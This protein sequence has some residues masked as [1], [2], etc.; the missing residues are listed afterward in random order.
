MDSQRW[1]QIEDILQSAMDRAPAQRDS[2]LRD[3]CG[4]DE[5]LEREV[6]SLLAVERPAD[7][8]LENP[9]IEVAARQ[10]T[11]DAS[12]DQGPDRNHD[13]L[14]G[15][16]LSHYRI[17]GKLGAGGMGQVYRAEDLRLH[18]SVAL[19]F[20]SDDFASDPEALS[21]FRR[22]AQ[23]ASALNHP[24]I[25]TIYDI[26]EV[27]G[28]SFIVMEHLEGA[29]LKQRIAE[30][31]LDAESLLTLGI[32]IADALDA[33]HTAGI[34]H[35]DIKPDNI[36]VTPRGHAKV[37]DFGLARQSRAP[38][39][40]S[41]TVT[42]DD[43]GPGAVVGTVA[44]MSPEQ[45]L[46]KP[47]DTRTDLFSF[48]VMLYE[49]ATGIR[50]FPGNTS[51]AVFAAILHQAPE[52]PVR[53]N[54][55]VPVELERVINKCLEKDRDLRYQHAAE[56][57]ADLRRLKRDADTGRPAVTST[58]AHRPRAGKWRLAIAAAFA[59]LLA[60]AGAAFYYL[61]GFV[62][63]PARLTGKDT[64]VLADFVNT[65]GDPVFD[66][67]MRQ[68]LAVQLEQSPLILL[69][70]QARIQH[71]L[72]LM[73][74]PPDTR[75][76]PEI[77][78]E[79]CQRA[80][81]AAELDGSIT[82][83][84]SKYVLGLTARNC[85]TG[86]ILYQ[87]QAQAEKKEDVLEALSQIARKFRAVVGESPLTLTKYSTPL[88]EATTSSLE[89]LEA[90]SLGLK[91]I[92]TKGPTDALPFF[93]HATELDPKFAT[94]YARLGRCYC[95]VEEVARCAEATRK[96]WELRDRASQ[97]EKYFID[98]SYYR[99]VAHDMAKAQQTCELW[100]QAYPRDMQPHAFLG[101]STSLAAG[102]FDKAA[103]ESKKAI[104]LDPDHPF[105]YGNLAAN[106]VMRER[107][108]E[109][110]DVI[111]RAFERRLA[112]PELVVL[113]YQVAFLR[114]DEAE[115]KR[116]LASGRERDGA[117][118]WVTDLALT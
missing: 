52:A 111:Q 77:A 55:A 47:L 78:R 87:E 112:I 80:S 26:G 27:D 2:F 50:P 63:G 9:A 4:G 98:F 1:K 16:T 15:R 74:R 102:K 68:G 99:L 51:G 69:I 85:R 23:A 29:S 35:R 117:D 94:A 83:L 58:R 96:A 101:G 93:K 6:R 42:M 97:E 71:I 30:H 105:P 65:T 90:Y 79:I 88:A 104:E 45:V 46:G 36:F 118:E 67:T 49:M 62:H 3:A 109:A 24:N 106:H 22:E 34:V 25:C 8:F 41:G 57:L 21:R 14:I 114:G 107:L 37:L 110:H 72:R 20:L 76:T 53:L 73:D 75:L 100:A 60:V 7:R 95:D 54:P 17:A 116:F 10:V 56:I 31:P 115:M 66:E 43:T 113:G 108:S 61:A 59:V 19:K 28:R 18:R 32:E 5:A 38:S 48:G 70:S 13:V 64:L 82:R 103:E 44:Y 92:A 33:A 86:D 89:A 84:G 81:G 39:S 11:L 40:D 12:G 91:A